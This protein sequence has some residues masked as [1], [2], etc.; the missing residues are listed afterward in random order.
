MQEL[1]SN[2]DLSFMSV[3]EQIWRVCVEFISF[4]KLYMCGS[5]HLLVLPSFSLAFGSA[6]RN[7]LLCGMMG[8]CLVL[9]L[10]A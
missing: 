1:V 9:I 3:I 8:L 5:H 4:E 7:V 10:F 6:F 2:P